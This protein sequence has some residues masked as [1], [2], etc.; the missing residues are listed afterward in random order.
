MSI[1]STTEFPWKTFNSGFQSN[2]DFITILSFK[3]KNIYALLIRVLVEASKNWPTVNSWWA[4]VSSRLRQHNAIHISFRTEYVSL[5]FFVN[6]WRICKCE[7]RNR[8]ENLHFCSGY[9]FFLI[10]SLNIIQTLSL[11]SSITSR[12]W[13]FQFT[14]CFLDLLLWVVWYLISENHWYIYFVQL[15]NC[16][17]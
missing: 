14:F 8:R 4:S 17:K 2:N 11:Y 9:Y 5:E 16:F 1:F 15:L 10:F 6:L 12:V 7:K 13:G 3:K